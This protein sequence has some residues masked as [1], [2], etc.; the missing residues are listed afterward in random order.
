MGEDKEEQKTESEDTDKGEGKDG[1]DA[2]EAA[3]DEDGDSGTQAENDDEKENAEKQQTEADEK[4]DDAEEPESNATDDNDQAL[5]DEEP[6]QVPDIDMDVSVSPP[7]ETSSDISPGIPSIKGT[8]D[9]IIKITNYFNELNEAY[10]TW[11]ENHQ[12]V[13]D[14]KNE[15][16]VKTLKET[17][18]R[19]RRW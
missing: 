17:F 19:M 7:E 15:K 14:E 3:D 2:D 13:D 6:D 9:N 10:A 12:Q 11:K 4:G 1:S 8:L 16:L 5:K 18:K